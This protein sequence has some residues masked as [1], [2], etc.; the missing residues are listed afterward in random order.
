[1]KTPTTITRPDPAAEQAAV[2][3]GGLRTGRCLPAGNAATAPARAAHA[4]VHH[5]APMAGGGRRA[6]TTNHIVAVGA[7]RSGRSGR[8]RITS[9]AA[10]DG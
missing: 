6:R 9:R 10:A 5:Q 4:A 8:P 3:T 2:R 1:M 7:A